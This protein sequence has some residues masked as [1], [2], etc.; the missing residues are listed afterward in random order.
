[1]RATLFPVSRSSTPRDRDDG[2]QLPA[3]QG[4][5]HLQVERRLQVHPVLRRLS[6]RSAKQQCQ[7]CRDG[8]RTPDN[9]RNTHGR[10]P[11][12]AREFGLGHP[13]F[14]KNFCEVIAGMNR[15]QPVFHHCHL[16]SVV[17]DNLNRIRVAILEA[18]AKAP[19]LVD[20]NVPLTGPVARQ[21]L[22]LIGSP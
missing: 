17:I 18:E 3:D 8:A 14:I 10:D 2:R 1:M 16:S 21:R 22:Q 7:L 19:L 13:Q 4:L 20:S 9:V 15:R 11:D 5:S 6:E 12:A